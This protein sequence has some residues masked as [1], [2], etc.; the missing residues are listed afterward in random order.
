MSKKPL[1]KTI[2]YLAVI[3]GLIYMYQGL[4]TKLWVYSFDVMQ[5]IYHFGFVEST[6]RAISI[7]LGLSQLVFGIGIIKESGQQYMHYLNISISLIAC[8][9]VLVVFPSRLTDA[10]NPVVLYIA[11]IGISLISLNL[12]AAKDK[13]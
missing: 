5:M 7:L 12:I 6:S 8:L 13:F 2:Q 3:I 10:F 11:L 4:I 1:D 9:V